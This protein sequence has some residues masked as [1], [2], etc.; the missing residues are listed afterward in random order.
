MLYF[1]LVSFIG[2]D[3]NRSLFFLQNYLNAKGLVSKSD[4]ALSGPMGFFS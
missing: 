2:I 3:I 1:K 4:E